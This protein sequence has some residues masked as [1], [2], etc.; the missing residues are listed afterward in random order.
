ML[1]QAAS[2]LQALGM[3]D[4]TDCYDVNNNPIPCNGAVY[5]LTIVNPSAPVSYSYATTA[6]QAA[7]DAATEV[8]N[9][10]LGLTDTEWYMLLGGGALLLVLVAQG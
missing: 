10:A 2:G 9:G 3:A 5:G 7:A 6:D 8:F 4:S 1:Q